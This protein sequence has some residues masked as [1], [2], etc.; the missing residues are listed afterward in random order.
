MIAP[1]NTLFL[2]AEI[3]LLVIYAFCTTY[4]EGMINTG[5]NEL[6]YKQQDLEAANAMAR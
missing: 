4:S 1:F 6:D 3:I 5:T 2:A